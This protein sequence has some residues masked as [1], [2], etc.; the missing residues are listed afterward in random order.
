MS[1]DER[2]VLGGPLRKC[3]A[4]PLTGFYRD[5]FCWTA[6]EDE[7][8]HVVCVQMTADF[9]EFS[10]ESGNDLSTPRPDLMFPGLKSGDLWCL[11]ALRWVEAYEAGVAPRIKL[12]ATHEKMLD[13]VPLEVLKWYDLNL[14]NTG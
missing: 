13:L 1:S 7:G 10:R 14:T 6:P 8:A 2:N 11:C 3:C 4:N 9:L 12:E 5:G